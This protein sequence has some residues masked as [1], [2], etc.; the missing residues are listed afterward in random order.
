LVVGGLLLLA[1]QGI[2]VVALTMATILSLTSW[3]VTVAAC[4]TFKIGLGEL[5]RALMPGIALASSGAVPIIS[6]S[7]VDLGFAPDLI[8]AS[9]LLAAAGI[10]MAVCSATVC[11]DFVREVIAL[12]VSAKSHSMG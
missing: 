9:A 12:I 3:M 6:L 1:S 2:E 8:E 11:R 4:R 7:F 5:G 10:G